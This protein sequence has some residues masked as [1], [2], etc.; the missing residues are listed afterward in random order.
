MPNSDPHA[1]F[2]IILVGEEETPFGIQ[3]DLLI[4]KSTYFQEY[5]AKTREQKVEEVIQFPNTSP[6]V[7]GLAQL[8]MFTG[9]LNTAPQ[10]LP[11][12]DLLIAV[13]KLGDELGIK[14]L[15]EEALKVMAEYRAATQSIPAPELLV[16]AWKDTA[17]GSPIR[18]L[19]LSWIAEYIRSS[20]SRAEFTKALPQEVLSEL[21]VVM[22]HSN[23]AP[24]IQ[25]KPASSPSVQQKNV[26]YL[27]HE[28]D[29][30]GSK[31]TKHRNSEVLPNRVKKTA[32]RSSLPTAPKPP[33]AKRA[34]LGGDDERRYT[35]DQKLIFCADLMTRMLSGPGEFG[36]L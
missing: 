26:H 21:V 5:F 25:V 12:Y 24:I 27:D 14:G 33:K 3:K 23:S 13:W 15:S 2:C 35:E 31:A 22:S 10:S 11:G 30:R 4:A 16:T 36:L 18:S 32:S 34:S 1:L 20:A 6:M 8:F 9:A 29:E 19:F 7:F 17:E 28:A